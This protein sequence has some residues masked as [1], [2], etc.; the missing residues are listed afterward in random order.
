[1]SGIRQGRRR[2]PPN[3][4]YIS[5]DSVGST[6]EAKKRQRSGKQP[7]A[8]E[9][10]NQEGECKK[11]K[12][13]KEKSPDSSFLFACPF[14]KWDPGKYG[15]EN[16]CASWASPNIDTVIRVSVS[17]VKSHTFMTQNDLIFLQHHVL[18]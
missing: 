2:H 14:C 7:R 6:G 10:G 3:D 18:D 12:M 4:G 9:H 1:M 8:L 17:F 5:L 16:G 13:G 15:G 11:S